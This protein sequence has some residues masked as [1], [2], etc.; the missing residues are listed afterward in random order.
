MQ[1]SASYSKP[2]PATIPALADCPTM[3]LAIQA[4]STS[5]CTQHY[6]HCTL[7]LA[8]CKTKPCPHNVTTT[9]CDTSQCTLQHEPLLAAITQLMQYKPL[10][11]GK[12]ALPHRNTNRCSL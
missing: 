3:H 4:V 12:Q 9:P 10:L 6:T 11:T 8:L 5:Y 7:I 2:L 1:T